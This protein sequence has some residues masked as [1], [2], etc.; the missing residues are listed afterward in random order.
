MKIRDQVYKAVLGRGATLSIVARRLLKQAKIWKTK[1]VA[2]GVRDGRTIHSLG[3]FTVTVLLGDEQVTQHCKVL[4]TDSFDIVIGPDFVR[5]NPQGKAVVFATS[6]CP[7]LQLWEW[8][9]LCPSGAV[10]TKRIKSALR[11]PVLS[12]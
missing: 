3:G 4:D 5:R 11:E 10:R 7:S 1:N 2:I 9:F 8:P 6:L 12:N